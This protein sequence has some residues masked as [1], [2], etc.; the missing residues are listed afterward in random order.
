MQD[1]TEVDAAPRPSRTPSP[2]RHREERRSPTP[3]RRRSDSRGRRTPPPVAKPRHAPSDPDPTNV[4][5][6]F[7]LSVR[8]NEQDLEDE[9]SRVS[10]VEKVVIVYDARVMARSRGFG[11]VTMKSVEGA[12][13]AIKELNGIELHGRRLRVDYSVT[14]KPHEPTPGEYRGEPRRDDFGMRGPP[15]QFGMQPRGWGGPQPWFDGPQGRP[16]FGGYYGGPQGPPRGG[17]YGGGRGRGGPPPPG[18]MYGGRP[19]MRGGF[20]GGPGGPGRDFDDRGGNRGGPDGDD[21]WRRP[22]RERSQSPARRRRARSDS[23]SPPPRRARDEERGA[24]RG[25]DRGG[26]RG[27]DRGGDRDRERSDRPERND[28]GDRDRSSPPRRSNRNEWD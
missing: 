13:S 17:F 23:R 28:R 22:N 25:G 10:P 14:N 12:T 19:P 2:R 21:N 8:T 5:G 27:G 4:V 9:F 7:G 20:R 15:G 26:E 11:F 6:V 16:P 3:E 18:G 1:Y 24:E